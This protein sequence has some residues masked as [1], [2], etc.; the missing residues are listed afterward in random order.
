MSDEEKVLI[1]KNTIEEI[2]G[3]LNRIRLTTGE[4]S[5]KSIAEEILNLLE[6][7]FKIEEE[8]IE[9][10]IRKKMLETKNTNPELHFKFYM[11]YRKLID[12]RI[13]EEDALKTY[14]LYMS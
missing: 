14:E 8:P 9:E 5:I 3:K 6:V 13:T 7:E 4:Y 11:L 2:Q 10:V 12:K 1:R